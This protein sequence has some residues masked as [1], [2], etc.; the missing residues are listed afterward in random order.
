MANG[1]Y[2][3]MELIDS[4]ILDL[5]NLP[6]E[7]FDGQYIQFCTL[8]GQMGQKLAALRKGVPADIES[9]DRVIESLKEQ[10][11]HAGRD[12]V[13]MSIDEFVKEY[14]NGGADHGTD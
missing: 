11:R 9:K 14:G 4:I 12:V 5:N 7:L 13:D 3:N 10:L 2:T 6:K 8:V 1:L